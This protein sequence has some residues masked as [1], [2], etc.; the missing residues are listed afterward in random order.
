[1]GR[2]IEVSAEVIFINLFIN[3]SKKATRGAGSH[4]KKKL[5]EISSQ[6][7]ITKRFFIYAF[8]TEL[9]GILSPFSTDLF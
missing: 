9:H 8:F 2:P 6:E 4:L 5:D 7:V 3:K 1:M